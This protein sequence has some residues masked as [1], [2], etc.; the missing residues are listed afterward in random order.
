M[1]KPP[2]LKTTELQAGG[3]RG[4]SC[5][6]RLRCRPAPKLPRKMWLIGGVIALAVI[7]AVG[8]AWW[9]S[10]GSGAVQYTTAPVTRGAVTRDGDGDRHGQSRA[11][12]H[13]R[14]LCVR[15]DP[16]AVMR[17]QH[18]GEEGPAL[19]QD[20]SAPLSDRRRPGQG[21]SRVA[22]AQLEKDKANLAY[23]KLDLRAQRA[24]W[25]RPMRSPRTRST[26]PRAAYDQAQA[27]IGV[28]RGHHR[29]SAKPRLTPR[30]SISATPI[31]FHRST[32]PSCRAT[33]PWGRRWPPA[34]RRRRC[35]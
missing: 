4:C 5:R 26:T 21:Q 30:R 12:D 15:R 23:A 6:S 7:A 19:R 17:L 22:K 31:S 3:A 24:S 11:H 2:D 9:L 14:N 34:S 8:I 27:Q 13:R 25:R 35:S 16:G 1:N 32:A 33:S 29:S 10:S 18:A 20:R 28:R